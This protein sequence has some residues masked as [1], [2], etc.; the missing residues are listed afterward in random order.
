MNSFPLLTNE[1]SQVLTALGAEMREFLPLLISD[2]RGVVMA[3]VSL[4]A[5]A[6]ILNE[7]NEREKAFENR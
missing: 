7:V 2:L 1:H 4:Y 5:A 3:A 6:H